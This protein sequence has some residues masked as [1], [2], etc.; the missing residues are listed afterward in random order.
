MNLLNYLNSTVLAPA[1]PEA[2]AQ[3]IAQPLG[4][5]TGLSLYERSITAGQR[6]LFALGRQEGIKKLVCLSL[7]PDLVGQF[8]GEMRPV[9]WEGT[10]LSF[11]LAATIPKNAA[12]LRH[13]LPFLVA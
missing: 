11:T 5:L 8:G 7:D 12:R 9:E 10:T 1:L 3:A 4:E 6:A 2:E 13:L